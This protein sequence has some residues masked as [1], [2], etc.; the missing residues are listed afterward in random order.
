MM[1]AK[2]KMQKCFSQRTLKYF[3]R[4][5]AAATRV[6]KQRE[7]KIASLESDISML[8]KRATSKKPSKK[9]IDQDVDNLKNKIRDL[10]NEERT[11]VLNQQKKEEIMEQMKER[12]DMIDEKIHGLGHVHS[13]TADQYMGRVDEIS[14]RLDQLKG[15]EKDQ[16]MQE[17]REKIDML[18]QKLQGLGHVHSIT[19]DD[20]IKRIEAMQKRLGKSKQPAKS[21]EK[22]LPEHHEKIKQIESMIKHAE[23]RHAELAKKKVPKKHLEPLRAMID[24]HKKKLDEIKG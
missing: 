22:P 1:A 8:H 7:D 6:Q 17:L 18:E 3:V 20:H 12:L 14:K 13:M 21:K 19:S 15:F 4:H 11:L 24:T 9:K 2:Q 5:M 23:K 10:V 16:I